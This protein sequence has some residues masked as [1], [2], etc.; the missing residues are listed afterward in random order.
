MKYYA[1]FHTTGSQTLVLV[2][3]IIF[4]VLANKVI[5][6]YQD[7]IKRKAIEALPAKVFR[8]MQIKNSN[9]RRQKKFSRLSWLCLIPGFGILIGIVLIFYSI[10]EF[11]SKA[12]FFRVLATM[13]GGILIIVLDNAYLKHDLYYNA[14][15]DG[16]FAKLD[17]RN[18]D[19]LAQTLERYRLK[20]GNYPDSL[21]QLKM[22]YP[23]VL[24]KDFLIDRRSEPY[25]F[26]YYYY[27]RKGEN[28]ILF[29]SGI[30]RIPN[31]ADDIYPRSHPKDSTL[32]VDFR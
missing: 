15:S 1:M 14:D 32:K 26:M 25:K 16:D 31:T 17:A 3:I 5:D 21:P 22:E 7:W 18:L 29:S 9:Q 6:K 28:Y 24:I 12:L 11:R 13:A 30:D 23:R 27:T 2:G 10:L 8:M 20:Y 4:C 19:D